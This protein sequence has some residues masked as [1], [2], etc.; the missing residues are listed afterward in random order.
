MRE[1]T[2]ASSASPSALQWRAGAPGC[3][4]WQALIILTS[5]MLRA[6]A[7]TERHAV[8]TLGAAQV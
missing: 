2:A 6:G 3:V 5:V 1:Y 4:P 8:D 7:I